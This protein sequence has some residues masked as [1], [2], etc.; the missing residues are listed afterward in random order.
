MKKQVL[1]ALF[2]IG[3]LHGFEVNTHQALTRC[4][5]T[6]DC[7][8]NGGTGNLDDFIKNTN[9]SGYKDYDKQLFTRSQRPRWECI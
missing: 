5:I 6:D 9:L 7:N 1:M 8:D 4:A 2:F 3:Y